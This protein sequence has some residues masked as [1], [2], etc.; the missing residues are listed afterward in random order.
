MPERL[1][2]ILVLLFADMCVLGHAYVLHLR[3]LVS[4]MKVILV[5]TVS[6]YFKG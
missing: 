4:E 2:G 3:F 6:G 5:S 1:G